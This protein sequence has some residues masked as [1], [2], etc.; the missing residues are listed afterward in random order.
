MISKAVADPMLFMYKA[1]LIIDATF[2]MN[3]RCWNLG[4]V[5][6][7]L[8]RYLSINHQRDQT[9]LKR[10]ITQVIRQAR[11]CSHGAHSEWR[12]RI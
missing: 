8:V 11:C 5:V 12:G 9:L 7:G 2:G 10:L 4:A 6:E 1:N 3:R